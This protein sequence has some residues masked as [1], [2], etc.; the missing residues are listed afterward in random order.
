MN[1]SSLQDE[2]L[3]FPHGSVPTTSV[4]YSRLHDLYP[5]FGLDVCKVVRL[6]FIRSNPAAV[7][8]SSAGAA[9]LAASK[10]LF[11]FVDRIRQNSGYVYFLVVAKSMGYPEKF[12]NLYRLDLRRKVKSKRLPKRSDIYRAASVSI[13]RGRA[14]SSGKMGLELIHRQSSERNAMLGTD[15]LRSSTAR[16]VF[17]NPH[18][19][20]LR[21]PSGMDFE[22][23]L[24]T[25]SASSGLNVIHDV[26]QYRSEVSSPS[27]PTQIRAT[28]AQRLSLSLSNSSSQDNMLAAVEKLQKK[29]KESS[30]E[31]YSN[32]SDD[33]G[34]K[35][36]YSALRC[37]KIYPTDILID[38]PD[39]KSKGSASNTNKSKK[40]SPV[41][42]RPNRRRYLNTASRRCIT[43]IQ[44]SLKLSLDDTVYKFKN[45]QDVCDL[46]KS[47]F[48]Y[49]Y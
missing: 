1:K 3:L 5:A 6:S 19:K 16:P 38:Q 26:V 23:D 44:E 20:R 4:I 45:R 11:N 39:K 13:A 37:L 30:I 47:V 49:Q 25:T 48:E 43:N 10:K 34:D 40:T 31:S 15:E 17:P 8:A 29:N 24:N 33:K 14:S 9:A 18:L 35:V 42:H 7:R 27:A 22:I 21:R 28:R 2:L 36:T 46:F 12:V 41:T 32:S